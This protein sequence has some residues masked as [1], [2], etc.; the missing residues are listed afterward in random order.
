MTPA[1]PGAERSACLRQ[2]GTV[3]LVP[4]G[5]EQRCGLAVA[6]AR[7]MDVE[8]QIAVVA[9]LHG[10]RERFGFEEAGQATGEFLS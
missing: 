5:G 2:R 1:S 3:L 7:G 6:E 10:A 4:H 9:H 8:L